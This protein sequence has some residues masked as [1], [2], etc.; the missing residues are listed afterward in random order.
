MFGWLVSIAV[1]G[2]IKISSVALSI[3]F[4][5]SVDGTHFIPHGAA[6]SHSGQRP[7]C[8]RAVLAAWGGPKQY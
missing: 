4:N 2:A 5:F 6:K 8:V 3:F 7:W 1:K